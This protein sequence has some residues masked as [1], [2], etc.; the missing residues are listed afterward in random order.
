MKKYFECLFF[1]GIQHVRRHIVGGVNCTFT[2][3]KH[4]S[5]CVVPVLA[6]GSQRN[7]P[8]LL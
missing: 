7:N 2:S 5:D 4:L 8:G 3:E 1:K 6:A